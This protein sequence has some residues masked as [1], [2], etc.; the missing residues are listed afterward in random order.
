MARENIPEP[1]KKSLSEANT[2]YHETQ[3][4]QK[5]AIETANRVAMAHERAMEVPPIVSGRFDHQT[6]VLTF[7][8]P[9]DPII[10]SVEVRIR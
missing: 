6:G 3:T 1:L 9:L 8:P 5:L 7:D 2:Q 4:A 10:S